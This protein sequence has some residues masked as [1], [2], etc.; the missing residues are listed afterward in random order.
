VLNLQAYA[1]TASPITF[2]GLVRQYYFRAEAEQG[3]IQVNLVDKAHR[4]EKSHAIAQRLRPAL[5]KIA[6]THQARIKVVE[7]PP[8]P[9]VL[10]P[11]VAEVYGPDEAGRQALATRVAQAFTDTPHIVGVDTS[12]KENAPRATL[13][14]RRQR[15]QAL[16]ISVAVIAQSA[17]MALAG[18]DVA[19]LHDGQS[20]YP[21][22]VRLQLPHT[23]QGQGEQSV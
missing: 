4:S 10:S 17:A 5:E 2:N 23:A 21:I 12:L 20:K 6:Q 8:G 9:P 3:D 13:R 16:G 22:P 15:A 11:L 1:G 19:Y 18:A 7:V 14:V